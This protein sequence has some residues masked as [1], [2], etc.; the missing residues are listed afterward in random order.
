LEFYARYIPFHRG[1]QRLTE[2]LTDYFQISLSGERVVRRA[3][4]WWALDPADYMCRDLF[5]CGAKDVAQLRVVRRHL[6][7]GSVMVDVGANFGYYASM[8]ARGLREQ[9]TVHAFEPNPAAFARLVGN[10]ERNGI[11]CVRAHRMGLWDGEGTASITVDTANTGSAYLTNGD[12]VPVVALDT[13]C[14]EHDIRRIDLIKVDAEGSELRVLHG[15]ANTLATLRP[16][17]LL[18]LNPGALE[19]AGASVDHVLSFLQQRRYSVEPVGFNPDRV[20]LQR[21]GDRCADV[22]CTPA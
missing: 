18:E 2:Y 3:G 1:K 4:L 20:D 21:L 19:R 13:F 11:R 17:L 8:V 5:W 9:C 12:S 14:R 22:L 7:P 16:T 15:A 10:L 6:V